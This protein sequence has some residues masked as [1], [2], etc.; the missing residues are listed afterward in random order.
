MVS[1]WSNPESSPRGSK[2]ALCWVGQGSLDGE[3][4]A[5]KEKPTAPFQGPRCPDSQRP[6]EGSVGQ[7]AAK[8][9]MQPLGRGFFPPNTSPLSLLGDL[10]P[11]RPRLFTFRPPTLLAGRARQGGQGSPKKIPPTLRKWL[12]RDGQAGI[13]EGALSWESRGCIRSGEQRSRGYSPS[14][15]EPPLQKRVWTRPVDTFQ[16]PAQL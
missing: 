13:L 14:F 12:G 15:S 16:G 10:L 8:T 1:R 6:R 3:D 4:L 9:Q 11:C 2:L 7:R 5:G